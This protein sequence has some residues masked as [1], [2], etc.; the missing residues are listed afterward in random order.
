[1]RGADKGVGTEGRA[2]RRRQWN[3][4]CSS[5]NVHAL[6]QQSEPIVG[7]LT[8]PNKQCFIL[9][10]PEALMGYELL[11]LDNFSL[12][13]AYHNH[14]SPLNHS[15]SQKVLE[16]YPQATENPA[17]G[18]SLFLMKNESRKMKISHN[19]PTKLWYSEIQRADSWISAVPEL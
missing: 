10:W 14:P 11:T 18:S 1:M 4:F 16:M 7:P 13:V 8:S 6:R 19:Y 9:E 5:S 17:Q 2:D 12:N 15:A 3:S